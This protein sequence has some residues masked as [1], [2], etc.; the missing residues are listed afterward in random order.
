MGFGLEMGEMLQQV[1]RTPV[2]GMYGG[3]FN[4]LH[5]GHVHCIKEALSQ[6]DVLHL[7]IGDLP[8]RDI[9]PYAEKQKWF[10][11]LF[12]CD[13][14][15]GRLVLH[16]LIDTTV[17]KEDYTIFRWLRDSFI[18]KNEIG[19]HIDKVFCGDDY[20]TSKDSQ[21]NPY[22]VCYPGSEVVYLSRN[23]VPISS[24]E[25]RA[26]IEKC[27]EYLPDVVFQR[28]SLLENT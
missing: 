1:S 3:S 24:I 16:R 7:V 17:N 2:I 18:I 5:N 19:C 25:I 14:S 10:E 28:L 8:G 9:V 13:I 27:K 20:K 26:D 23:E 6:W 21:I 15:S 4:P 22:I 11:S 12:Q